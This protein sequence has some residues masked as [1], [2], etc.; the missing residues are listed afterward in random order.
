MNYPQQKPL[1]EEKGL[2]GMAADR[3]LSLRPPEAK[4]K[5]VPSP[6]KDTKLSAPQTVSIA[7]R[8]DLNC[9]S[10]DRQEMRNASQAAFSTHTSISKEEIPERRANYGREQ[11]L[12]DE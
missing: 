5:Q 4:P 2:D 10:C 9:Q 6:D 3:S 11:A 12:H 8:A 7:S 1:R